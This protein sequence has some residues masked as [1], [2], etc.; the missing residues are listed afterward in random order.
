MQGNICQWDA[1]DAHIDLRAV[2]AQKRDHGWG[3]CPAL[4]YGPP[5]RYRDI[6]H[7]RP[8]AVAR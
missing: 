4:T 7:R 6:A 3:G 8:V 2:A 1:G 5:V